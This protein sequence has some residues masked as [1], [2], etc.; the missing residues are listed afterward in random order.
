MQ[1]EDTLHSDIIPCAAAG[2]LPELFALR[3]QRTP[4]A[5]AYRQFDAA[6]GAAG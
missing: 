6:G 4:E 3:I 1:P 5:P 2:T